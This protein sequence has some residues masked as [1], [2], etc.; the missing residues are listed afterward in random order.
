MPS[1]LL[2]HRHPEADCGIAFAAW[3][4]FVS[5]LRHGSVLASCSASPSEGDDHVL[6]WTVDA[7]DR[8]AALAMLPPWVA[9][10]TEAKPVGEVFVP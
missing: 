5:P 4:G 9:E 2:S 1:F 10:R 7:A 3:R 6:V 8:S